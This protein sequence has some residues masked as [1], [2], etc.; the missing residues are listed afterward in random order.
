MTAV[1]ADTTTISSGSSSSSSSS[2][3]DDDNNNNVLVNS[4]PVSTCTEIHFL[5][6]AMLI[7]DKY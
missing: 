4:D 2:S 6:Y 7:I 3:T 5:V 1:A